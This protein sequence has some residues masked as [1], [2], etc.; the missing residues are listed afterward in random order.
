MS[1]NVIQGIHIGSKPKTL[2]LT[3]QM[4]G[5]SQIALDCNVLAFN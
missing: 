3:D 5:V 4:L 1:D 2:K